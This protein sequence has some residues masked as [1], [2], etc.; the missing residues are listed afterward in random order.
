MIRVAALSRRDA[1]LVTD[2][3]FALDEALDYYVDVN[4]PFADDAERDVLER[5]TRVLK[6]AKAVLARRTQRRGRS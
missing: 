3:V 6:R 5:T 2:L 1:R 4:T